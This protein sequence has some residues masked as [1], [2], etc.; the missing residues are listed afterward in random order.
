VARAQ[1]VGA[2]PQ[3]AL[4]HRR[5]R[6]AARG[7]GRTRLP[8]RGERDRG[9]GRRTRKLVAA[10]GVAKALGGRELFRAL[11][12]ELGPGTRL[13]LLGA[14][15]SG[16]STLLRILGKELEPDAGTVNFADGL[17]A[18]TFEQGRVA[19]DQ[20][21]RLRTALCPNGDTVTFGD[22]QLHVAGWAARFLFAAEQLNVE[23]GALSGGE[24]ARVR[25]A[26]LMVQPA[27]LLLLD[28]PTNDLDIASVE[29][30]EDSLEEFPGAVVLVSHD[31]ELMDRLC[32]SFIGLDGRGNAS[33]YASVSQWLTATAEPEPA[34]PA[35]KKEA[36]KATAPAAKPKKLSFHEQREFD[37]MEA[38][39]VA[40]EA[41]VSAREAAIG[42]VPPSDHAA[43]TA[44]C[45]A[46]EGAQAAVEKLYA[47]WQEL[48]AKRG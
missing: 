39:I 14:N 10:T 45:K 47:R 19:L 43:L 16:K 41:E 36:A 35:A 23:I 2:A 12:V 8:H 29:A 4:A 32:T 46:L 18:V 11:D 1:G 48:E 42:S 15:G 24:Q 9:T 5:S 40:A 21:M 17:R 34:K 6:G 31:R 13:G 20:S 27:D 38:S 28:E 26:Q 37:G 30:L 7:V 3:V 44:A 25:V 33:T 22:R